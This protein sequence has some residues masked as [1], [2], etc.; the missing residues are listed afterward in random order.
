MQ[1]VLCYQTMDSLPLPLDSNRRRPDLF[2]VSVCTSL[3]RVSHS[4]EA[5][6]LAARGPR[7]LIHKQKKGFINF[8]ILGSEN[9]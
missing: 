7:W 5:S 8:E 2:L 4:R 3:M 9:N 6:H 1:K